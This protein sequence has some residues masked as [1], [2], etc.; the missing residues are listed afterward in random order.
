MV[1]KAILL[2]ISS[3]TPTKDRNPPSLAIRYNSEVILFDC[4]EGI[5]K[6][7]MATKTSYMDIE[8][9]FISHY[10]ADH[11]LGLPG[12]LATMSL[13]ERINQITIYGPKKIKD[14]VTDLLEIFEINLKYELNFVELKEGIVF[15]NEDYLIKAKRVRHSIETYG[16]VFTEKDVVGKFNKEKA[17]ALG[18]PE[19]PLF[20]QLKSGKAVEYKGKTFKP[21]QVMNYDVV[22]TGKS[23]G[24][25]VDLY[26]LTHKDFLKD[27]DI[28]F[29]EATF[30]GIDKI[31]AKKTLHSNVLDIAKMLE[32]T[33]VKKWVLMNFSTRY[34]DLQPLINEAQMHFPNAELGEELKEYVLKK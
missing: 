1:Y 18:L 3:S 32:K 8:K 6:Q 33:N 29:H 2:G 25:F 23:I 9:I 22:K 13:H 16:F 11:F 34:K 26:D 19:G 17:L 5:Q 30:L 15:E 27:V 20:S 7:L 12:L 28:L 21:E 14:K 10:H 24:Y 31:Q 4:A